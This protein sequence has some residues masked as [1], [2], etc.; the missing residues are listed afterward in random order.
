MKLRIAI[1]LCILAVLFA[2]VPAFADDASATAKK[3]QEI[4]KLLVD[5]L[6]KDAES[7]RV[8]IVGDKTTLTGQV[9]N[10]GTQELADEVLMY[11]GVTKKKIDNQ[12]KV[13]DEKGL[14]SGKTKKEMADYKIEKDVRSKVKGEIGDHAKAIQIECTN[15]TCSMRGTLPDQGRKD[16]AMKAA[17][18]VEGVK[19][20]VDLV[21]LK[22]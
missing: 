1:T 7:I 3:E 20:I 17:A 5:K 12:V 6:G 4:M 16:L 2:A 9:T 13:K 11:A 10:R 22:G 21:H 15:D 18:G 14:F 8:T 19:H